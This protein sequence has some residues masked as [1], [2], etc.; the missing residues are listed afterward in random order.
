MAD[1][2]TELTAIQSAIY[3]RDVRDSIVGALTAVNDSAEAAVEAATAGGGL[4]SANADL[5]KEALYMTEYSTAAL[6]IEGKAKIDTLIMALKSTG[7]ESIS[8][9]YSG[10]AV[11][12]GTSVTALTGVVVTATYTNGTS[13][14]VEGYTMSPST[15]AV[16]AN[17][18][19]VTYGGKTAT[20]S[21]TGTAKPVASISAVYS[22][23]SV[24]EGTSAADLR[25]YITVT[26][27]YED[28]TTAQVDGYAISGTVV[29]GT[30]DFAITY[31]GKTTTITVTGTEAPKENL[32]ETAAARTIASAYFSM[33]NAQIR[34]NTADNWNT[35]YVVPVQAGKTY[36]LLYTT[37][38]STGWNTY[39]LGN[40]QM[41]GFVSL[42]PTGGSP[43]GG[44]SKTFLVGTF[45][46]DPDL[47]TTAYSTS[48]TLH[49]TAGTSARSTVAV[50]GGYR[51]QIDLT[52]SHDGYAMFSLKSPAS[53]LALN[54]VS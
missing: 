44:N 23:G 47:I 31:G 26:A 33:Y 1:I 36:R 48:F 14:T 17:T 28:S 51:H 11:V 21:V 38:Y 25:D 13:E 29:V 39:T 5:L 43:S 7:V 6:A 27:V 2:S 22:G 52:Y 40:L 30:N 41:S 50:D 42:E 16:G 53:N 46:E 9:S 10:G 32:L 3:G 19:T 45:E 8:V 24:V 18:I 37:E 12:E 49:E 4:S 20:F 34:Y 35:A 15:V 54:E